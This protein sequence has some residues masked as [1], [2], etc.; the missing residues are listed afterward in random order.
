[1]CMYTKRVE[2]KAPNFSK[3]TFLKNYIANYASMRLY[4]IKKKNKTDHMHMHTYALI[5]VLGKKVS[6]VGNKL[7]AKQRWLQKG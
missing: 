7:C 5:Y 2:E 1:M 3:H 6:Y 4:R